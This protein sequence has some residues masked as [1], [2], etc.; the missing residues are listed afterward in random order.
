MKRIFGVL[1]ALLVISVSASAQHDEHGGKALE[2]ITSPNMAPPNLL[3]RRMQRPLSSHATLTTRPATRMLRTF[4]P[5]DNG[6]GMTPGREMPATIWTTLGSTGDS[7]AVLAA[8]MCG[9]WPVAV[10]AAFGS[11]GSTLALPL[12]ISDTV[13]IG[14]G[15]AIR[16]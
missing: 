13:M 11:V 6:W 12:R 9:I 15:I 7:T 5:T 10:P 2:S 4:T 16:S 3:A 8:A 14:Y 1:V